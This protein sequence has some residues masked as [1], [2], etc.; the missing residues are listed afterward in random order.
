[1][2]GTT[3]GN[4]NPIIVC[5]NTSR[6]FMTRKT[7]S[8]HSLWGAI[9][10]EQERLYDFRCSSEKWVHLLSA[11][12]ATVYLLM[13]AADR[14]A[15]LAQNPNLA[16]TLLFTLGAHFRYL[17]EYCSRV[18]TEDLTT[19]IRIWDEWVFRESKNRTAIMYFIM[20]LQF[21]V[22]F[23]LPCDREFDQ[24]IDDVPLPSAKALWESKDHQAWCEE[25]KLFEPNEPNLIYGDLLAYNRRSLGSVDHHSNTDDELLAQRIERWQTS[26]DELGMIVSLG[27]TMD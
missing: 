8:D 24:V 21:D 27:S 15:A 4:G 23:G 16:T 9:T 13:L 20:A 3:A 6:H 10:L 14:E 5:Q 26:M 19:P 25:E 7:T 11:Q 12:A 17:N 1:M 22:N 2:L 18:S